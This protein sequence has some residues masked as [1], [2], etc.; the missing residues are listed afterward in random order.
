[1]RSLYLSASQ[2]QKFSFTR[3]HN[4]TKLFFLFSLKEFLIQLH[5]SPT[6]WQPAKHATQS[7]L[8]LQRATL[9][10]APTWSLVVSIHVSASQTQYSSPYLRLVTD[11]TGSQTSTK[12]IVDVMDIFGLA[13]QTL[14]GADLLAAALDALV[15]VPD[16]FKGEPAQG[17]WFAGGEENDKKKSAFM[18]KLMSGFGESLKELSAVVEDGKKTWSSIENWGAYGLC[19]GGKVCH[20]RL[21]LRHARD[22]CMRGLLILTA[23][24][25]CIGIWCRHPI[26][27]YRSSPSRVCNSIFL[28][29]FKCSQDQS[30]RQRGC[31]EDHN[32]SHCSGFKWRRSRRREG[33]C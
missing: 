1:M 33:V 25:R 9:L 28:L 14:Q 13:P 30:S 23:S 29:T 17:A 26:Q 10:K 27:G 8:S 15:L 12:A 22:W 20:F 5:A 21:L 6:R 19:W 2:Q 31:R 24:G 11:V 18:G 7:L 16:F 4:F 32:P 3:L